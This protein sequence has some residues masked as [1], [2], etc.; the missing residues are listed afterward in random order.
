MTIKTVTSTTAMA[1]C[2]AILAFPATAQEV[3]PADSLYLGR[4]II[5]YSEDGTPIYASDN[6]SVIEGDALTGQGGFTKLDD[7]VRQTPGV[8]TLLNAG[9]PGLAVAVRGLGGSKVDT[10]IEGVPQNY[11]MTAH[12]N[13][14]GFTYV[15]PMLLS[16]IEISRGSSIT[17]GGLS[18]SVN[19]R[20]LSADDLV[21][22][23][24]GTGGMVRLRYGD[25]GK[26]YA[27][28][29]AYGMK[30]GPIEL[31][32]AASRSDMDS[33]TNGAG[34]TIQDTD[35]EGG[36]VLL[37]GKYKVS[38]ALSLSMMAMHYKTSYGSTT[39]N[40][41]PVPPQIIYDMDVTN[42]ILDFGFDYTGDSDLF[43]LS[44]NLYLG[45]T[46]HVHATGN[47]SA[48]G[49]TNETESFGFNLKNTSVA[50]LGDWTLTSTN[51][52]EYNRDKLSGL[53]S[54]S[55]GSPFGTNPMTGNAKRMAVYSENVFEN[56]PFE[57]MFG[58]RYSDYSLTGFLRDTL[59]NPGTE[60]INQ[61]DLD[62]DSLDPKLSLAYRI[63]DN[64]QPYVSV[65]RTSRAPTAQEA[66]LGGGDASA[67]HGG[68][69]GN[70]ELKPEI[71]QG[72]EIGVNLSY[73]DVFASGDTLTSRI[74]V[75]DLEVENFIVSQAGP[76]GGG[77]QFINVP[78]KVDNK[79]LELELGYE[80]NRFSAV[81]A[82][83]NSDAKYGTGRLQPKNAISATLA[84]R[85][86]DG[87]L[88]LGTTLTY[89]SNGP[90][91]IAFETTA[92]R[93][94]YKTVD[95]FAS[96]NVTEDFRIDAKIANI[97]DELYTPWAATA[98]SG[99]GRAAYISAEMRF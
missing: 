99:V 21:E 24:E 96:Y 91:S 46:E 78:G 71:S 90:A 14:D 42:Q 29:S 36:S 74:N 37:R 84:G 47:G 89:N 65:Y 40:F 69:V 41:V 54:T 19:M 16:A 20:L 7:V 5:G 11:R 25:N 81:L 56:G 64:I 12:N 31:A 15:D 60:I 59:S 43:A 62:H 67:G 22:G 61:Y 8:T 92:N 45:S 66:F 53:N 68:F 50:E 72:Y 39:T 93:D 52:V 10:T 13:S 17:S 30:R 2:L 97:T 28:L 1:M 98:N 34:A 57:V 79:G 58:L 77:M 88:T 33:F 9:Q 26:G 32:F 85:F 48:L 87:D 73:D 3:A 23:D 83:A 38:D 76:M 51:G 94:S 44:G 86:L 70:P 35:Q 63:N 75:Y 18:G 27:A 49:R 80:S 6:T 55:S 4:I 95:I 82:W